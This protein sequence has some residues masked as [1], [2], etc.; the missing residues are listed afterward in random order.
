MSDQATNIALEALA[1]ALLA[2]A[3]VNALRRH[4]RDLKIP[5]DDHEIRRLSDFELDKELAS[6]DDLEPGFTEMVRQRLSRAR[7]APDAAE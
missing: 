1:S 5:I 6:L 7:R 2:S 3:E 4:L